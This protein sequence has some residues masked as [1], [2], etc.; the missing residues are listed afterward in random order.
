MGPIEGY[1]LVYKANDVSN[2]V[3]EDYATRNLEFTDYQTSVN[4]YGKVIDMVQYE[5][6][7]VILSRYQLLIFQKD[8]ILSILYNE[9]VYLD[10][11]LDQDP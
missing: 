7:I 5:E 8:E 9:T 4:F 1:Q 11:F 6:F 3:L 2:V 10:Y